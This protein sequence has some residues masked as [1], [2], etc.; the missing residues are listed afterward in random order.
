MRSALVG[1]SGFVGGT[2]SRT[3]SF[4]GLYNSRNIGEIA[5]QS[6]DLVVCAAAPAT[7]WAANQDPARDKANLD[8]LFAA[9][10]QAHVGHFVLISTIAVLDNPSAGYDEVNA[11]YETAKA[12]GRN[13]RE[14]E[15]N[16]AGHFA[17]SHILRLPALFGP[18]LKKNFLFDLLNP[19]PSF[20]K[21]EAWEKVMA[22]VSG[23][24]QGLLTSYYAL[25]EGLGMLG[26]DRARLDATDDLVRVNAIFSGLNM[27][28]RNFTNSASEF[29]YYNMERL[30]GDIA[31]V[32]EAG[33][34]VVNICSQPLLAA[35]ICLELTGER[36][37]NSQAAEVHEDMRSVHAGLFGGSGPYLF[38]AETVKGDLRAFFAGQ[39]RS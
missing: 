33:V 7:M 18:G 23:S 28:A 3:Q 26:L 32:V 13:R 22:A 31:T 35:D 20:I 12:Y 11:A 4:D 24:E 6:F 2:L 21:P 37:D 34:D 25:D 10:Q 15:A 8:G 14:L 1:Y 39:R 16:V 30:A 9:L 29:Q 38:D 17:Q 36:F 5:G 27:V 19:A